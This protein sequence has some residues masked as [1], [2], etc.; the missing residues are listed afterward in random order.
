MHVRLIPSAASAT[1]LRV[2]ALA[3][4]DPIW[5]DLGDLSMAAA[6]DPTTSCSRGARRKVSTSPIHEQMKIFKSEHISHI[7]ADLDDP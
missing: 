6:K 4:P 5:A 1:S 3:G 7:W 2:S